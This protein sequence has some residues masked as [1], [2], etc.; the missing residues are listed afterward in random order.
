MDRPSLLCLYDMQVSSSSALQIRGLIFVLL[1]TTSGIVRV[2]GCRPHEGGAA[3]SGGR[4]PKTF[5]S[6]DMTCPYP[7]PTLSLPCP[8]PVPTLV[9]SLRPEE[10]DPG[11]EVIGE[12]LEG[13]RHAR[14]RLE[15]LPGGA[16]THWKAPPL[17]GAHPGRT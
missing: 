9:T 1:N 12:C 13:V 5:T 17:H 16:C 2:F 10:D 15:R 14:F 11:L 6:T 3:H 7:V 4:R 8:Y